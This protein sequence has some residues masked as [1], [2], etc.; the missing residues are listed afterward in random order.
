LWFQWSSI[1]NFKKTKSVQINLKQ[2]K[3]MKENK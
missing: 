1:Y 2:T 3:L